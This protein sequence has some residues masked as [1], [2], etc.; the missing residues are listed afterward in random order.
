MAGRPATVNR[1]GSRWR[2]MVSLCAVA[3]LMVGLRAG[4]Q[5]PNLGSSSLVI[6]EESLPPS[7]H[8]FELFG[9][10]AGAHLAILL[11][12][13]LVYLD[14]KEN[15]LMPQLITPLEKRSA[16]QYVA[17]VLSE[18]EIKWHDG[19]PLIARD[20]TRSFDRLAEMAAEPDATLSTKSL[21][22]LVLGIVPAE[23]AERVGGLESVT[24]GEGGEIIFNFS[25]STEQWEAMQMLSAFL[26]LPAHVTDADLRR[27]PVGLGPYRMDIEYERGTDILLERND[28]YFRGAPK[29]KRLLIRAEP[30]TEARLK[31]ALE[32]KANVAVGILEPLGREQLLERNDLRVKP[33]LS[34]AYYY[35]GFNMSPGGTAGF[36]DRPW[37]REVVA[38][39]LD[40]DALL[41]AFGG[42]ASAGTLLT[43]PFRP[44]S[45]N[46]SR[47]VA[48]IQANAERVQS[49][50]QAEGFERV[51]QFYQDNEGQP[52]E[53]T[54]VFR[55]D[56]P[57]L[58]M[59]A[60][61]VREQL[62]RA[63]IGVRLAPRTGRDFEVLL[64]GE[65]RKFDLVLHRFNVDEDEEL[66]DVFHSKGV[67]NFLR[68]RNEKVDEVI[69]L[70]RN[71]TEPASRMHYHWRLHEIL[72]Q[73]IPAVFLWSPKLVAIMDARII[74]VPILDPYYFYREVH[75]WDL[76]DVA[77]PMA[78]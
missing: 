28:A 52:L 47:N 7:L 25:R 55:A 40:R 20:I 11:Y 8:P 50:F 29:I 67:Y 18:P 58:Q 1:A 26:V 16:R 39:V 59:L 12:Q 53:A 49:L 48:P 23:R 65:D 31:L 33:E 68:Y 5:T 17:R 13:H 21:A 34:R 45:A 35:L 3:L 75:R 66:Y 77:E 51:A 42:D 44:D 60:E 57:D 19:R 72:A 30:S 2:V 74:N 22:N 61:R 43:G 14:S 73:D 4:A 54:L 10:D 32:G 27:K 56:S 63:G 9:S 6:V 62:E 76:Q 70:A 41:T 64:A 69:E 36:G 38:R 78:F 24:E 37:L 46:A 15:A 71:A